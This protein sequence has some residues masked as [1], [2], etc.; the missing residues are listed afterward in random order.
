MYDLDLT[1]IKETKFVLLDLSLWI[2]PVLDPDNDV[3]YTAGHIYM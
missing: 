3:H 2:V 1:Q